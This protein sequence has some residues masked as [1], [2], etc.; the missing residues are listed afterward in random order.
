[1]LQ[2][3]SVLQRGKNLSNTCCKDANDVISR[4][5]T[6]KSIALGVPLGAPLLT[7]QTKLQIW[8]TKFLKTK[9]P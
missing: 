2:A 9:A 4:K 8:D 6:W 3:F 1:M 7:P 5:K